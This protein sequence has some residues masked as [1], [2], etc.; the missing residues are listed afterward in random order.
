MLSKCISSLTTLSGSLLCVPGIMRYCRMARVEGDLKAHPVPSPCHGQGCHPLD[1]VS[2][3]LS[4]YASVT[5][6]C[7]ERI[8]GLKIYIVAL[9]HCGHALFSRVIYELN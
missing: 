4:F 3:Q 6:V 2:K 9:R 1:H 8:F 5:V 7:R